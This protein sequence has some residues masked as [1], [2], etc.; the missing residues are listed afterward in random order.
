M[1]AAE[2]KESFAGDSDPKFAGGARASHQVA[3]SGADWG[4]LDATIVPR[5]EEKGRDF[6]AF[7]QRTSPDIF[8]QYARQESNL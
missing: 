4:S 2:R 7:H 3:Q 8:D 5:G 1:R 6:P